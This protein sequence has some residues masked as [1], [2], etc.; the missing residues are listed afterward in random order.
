[1][2]N[3]TVYV[4]SECDYQSPKWMGQCPSCKSWNTFSEET[5][6]QIPEPKNKR[7]S[8]ISES[9]FNS[10]AVKVNEVSSSP[11]IVEFLFICLLHISKF[12][13][14]FYRV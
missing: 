10:F 5:Y 8:I 4:C 3:K 11:I 12:F 6:T 13:N 2:K 14:I 1:M 9:S 7:V